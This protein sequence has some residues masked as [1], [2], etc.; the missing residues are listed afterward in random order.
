[1][2]VY[3]TPSGKKIC[4]MRLDELEDGQMVFKDM[5]SIFRVIRENC[6]DEFADD[7]RKLLDDYEYFN[8]EYICDSALRTE[9]AELDKELERLEALERNMYSIRKLAKLLQQKISLMN[10]NKSS[11]FK[12]IVYD[13]DTI[14][15][16]S[17]S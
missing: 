11:A 7:F 12:D 4:D 8:S 13:I 1:M 6:G 5:D 10:F 14:V 16:L 2:R 15:T 3:E 17:N 9:D